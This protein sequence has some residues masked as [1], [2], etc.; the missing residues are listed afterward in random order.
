L[1]FIAVLLLLLL[2]GCVES[3]PAPGP[4]LLE[5]AGPLSG[6]YSGADAGYLV[7]TVAA[8]ADTS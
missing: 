2:A 8:R 7:M 1:R 4:A 5:D 3:G 6:K